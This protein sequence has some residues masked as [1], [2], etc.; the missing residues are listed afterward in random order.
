[1]GINVSMLDE[2]FL[3]SGNLSTFDT[4]VV[5]VR[6]SEARPDFI[7]NHKRLME[8]V[9]NGGN[10][11]VQY[12]Q[13]NYVSE[14]LPPF[15]AKMRSRVT[16]ETAPVQILAPDHQV[17]TFP[18][19]ITS[20]DFDGWTQERNL[21]AFTTFDDRYKPLLQTAD[22]GENPQQGGQVYAKIGKGHYIYTAYAWFRQL[23]AGV[24]GAYRMFANLIS[25][26]KAPQP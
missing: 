13:T 7:E 17:F 9:N 2:N 6:A 12:Q 23:P 3:T 4:I 14:N 21:Y 25:L 20:E 11:I 5:G 19:H 26:P 18:N 15:P 8:Y 22:P 16:D 10:L 24:P 1:M